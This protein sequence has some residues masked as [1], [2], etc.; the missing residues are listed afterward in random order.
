VVFL[1]LK[2]N[3]GELMNTGGSFEIVD[4][5]RVLKHQTNQQPTMLHSEKI[6]AA[7]PKTPA[8]NKKAGDK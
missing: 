8:K 5:K 3:K 6:A 4:G 1:Y 2:I 7:N